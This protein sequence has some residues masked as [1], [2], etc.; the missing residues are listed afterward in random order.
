[1]AKKKN[2]QKDVTDEIGMSNTDFVLQ[3]DEFHKF[4]LNPN[5]EKDMF[6]MQAKVIN[7]CAGLIRMLIELTAV[8]KEDIDELQEKVK[9]SLALHQIN[10]MAIIDTFK[11]SEYGATL[12][13]QLTMNT[14]ASPQMAD[15]ATE[16]L[17]HLK[18][19]GRFDDSE[20]EEMMFHVMA[21]KESATTEEE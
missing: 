8:L 3:P 7:T 11:D 17:N 16:V 12:L 5:L 13:E 14:L 6:D 2:K 1:M 15:A 18:G 21:A 4:T 10:S 20:I 9:N 19:K